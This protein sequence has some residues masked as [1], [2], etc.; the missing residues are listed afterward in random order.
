MP[1]GNCGFACC[2]LD[3]MLQ[4]K[5]NDLTLTFVVVC[6]IRTVSGNRLRVCR[7][8]IGTPITL[9]LIGLPV[10][11]IYSH[12]TPHSLM[13][14]TELETGVAPHDFQSRADAWERYV[15]AQQMLNRGGDQDRQSIS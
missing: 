14:L 9:Q 11:M 6:C 7:E 2:W 5:C 1:K 3:A 8:Q 13:Y 10:P 15:Q 4:V 12:Q